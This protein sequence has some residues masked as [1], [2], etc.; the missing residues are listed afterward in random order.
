MGPPKATSETSSQP[1]ASIHSKPSSVPRRAIH[2]VRVTPGTA[3]I[4]S[5]VS[6][7]IHKSLHRP[8]NGEATVAGR[9]HP[10]VGTQNDCQT[11]LDDPARLMGS[12]FS[13]APVAVT[14][15]APLCFCELI[16]GVLDGHS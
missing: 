5:Q 1:R 3:A 14:Q 6:A 9:G 2:V 13:C 16:G 11:Q 12:Y 4:Y 8:P 7:P 15:L 10:R